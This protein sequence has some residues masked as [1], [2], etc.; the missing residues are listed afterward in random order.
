VTQ[1]PKVKMKSSQC[2]K[3]DKYLQDPHLLPEDRLLK[4]VQAGTG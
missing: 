3:P 2:L 1:R 4:G